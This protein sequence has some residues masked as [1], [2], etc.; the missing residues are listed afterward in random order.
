[1]QHTIFSSRSNCLPWC[2][3]A[4]KEKLCAFWVCQNARFQAPFLEVNTE[5]KIR[6]HLHLPF[7]Y[8]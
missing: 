6:E 2:P 8:R 5:P 3:E 7:G 4:G 1:M